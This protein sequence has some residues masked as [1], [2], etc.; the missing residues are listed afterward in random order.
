MAT[1]AN[2][3]SAALANDEAQIQGT[4]EM[5][6]A[7]TQSQPQDYQSLEILKEAYQK[8]GR[9]KDVANTSKRI[10]Q[11]YVMMGQLS[12]AI[13]EYESVIQRCPD[14][15]E[16]LAAL[17]E[18][19]SKASSLNAESAA[20]SVDGTRII[21]RSNVKA[22]SA[23]PKGPA[24]NIDDGR[25]VFY[26]LFVASK[27]ISP[28]DFDACWPKPDFSDPP[29][30]IA[31]PFIQVLAEKN[32]VPTDKSL[33]LLTDKYRSAYL[34]LDRYDIDIEMARSMPSAILK[35]WCILPFDRMSKSIL[36]ATAN[37]FNKCA[38]EELEGVLKQRLVWYLASPN[39]LNKA[40]RKVVR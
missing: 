20:D 38:I 13:M 31:E 34:P 36:I 24:C 2:S 11:A 17:N 15:A 29:Q 32:L 8:L 1:D 21:T 37:P 18:L 7:I 25:Q 39:D 9:D 16:A 30:K 6:E 23:E 35:R 5:F 4:I 14:D 33:K 27:L 10:A 3:T 28:A 22:E 12:S 40:L 26:K 19:E